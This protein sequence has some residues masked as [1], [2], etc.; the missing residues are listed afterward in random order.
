MKINCTSEEIIE[1][2]LGG[3]FDCAQHIHTRKICA[4]FQLNHKNYMA[5]KMFPFLNAIF[6]SSLFC[7]NGGNLCVFY[8]MLHLIRKANNERIVK[9]CTQNEIRSIFVR[10]QTRAAW[11]TAAKMEQDP[12][13]FI[14]VEDVPLLVSCLANAWIVFTMHGSRVSVVYCSKTV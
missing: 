13:H 3:K 10:I 7:L 2:N 11:T 5:N 14:F 12:V 8:L 4:I 1:P 9:K 6:V